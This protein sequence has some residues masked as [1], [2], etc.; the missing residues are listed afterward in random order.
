MDV[1]GFDSLAELALD[2]RSEWNHAADQVWRWLDP[3]LWKL[4]HNPW[5]ILQTVSREKL[6]GVLA[7]DQIKAASDLGVPVIG[8]GLLYQQGYFRQAIDQNGAQ[9]ALFPYND[10]GQLPITPLREANGEWLRLEIPLPGYSV[11][12]RTWQVQVG[13]LKLYLLD[14]N[15]AERLLR[16]LTNPQRPVQ[17]IIAGKAHPADLAGQALI[18]EWIHFIRRPEARPHVRRLVGGGLHA[19]SGL[20]LGGWP[21]AW[22]RSRVGRGRSRRALRSARAGG[23]SRILY[24]RRTRY[25]NRVGGADARKHGAADTVFFHLGGAFPCRWE[26]MNSRAASTSPCS[27]ATPVGFGWSCSTNRFLKINTLTD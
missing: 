18:Q 13:R 24:P 15:D 17:L 12:L 10:P 21:G 20:G 7:G 19:G 27:A 14:S 1:E 6:Q 3:V 22:R 16:L 4:T 26:P 9:Q 11:W 23:D 5:G 2:M 25:P 8:V